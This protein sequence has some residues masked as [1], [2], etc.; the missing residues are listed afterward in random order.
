MKVRDRKY[1][2]LQLRHQN[3]TIK[4]LVNLLHSQSMNSRYS[5][6]PNDEQVDALLDLGKSLIKHGTVPSPERVV[7]SP[8]PPPSR[9][10]IYRHSNLNLPLVA[11]ER[12]RHD[13]GVRWSPFSSTRSRRS[14]LIRLTKVHE[15]PPISVLIR[16]SFDMGHIVDGLV[17]KGVIE[18]F[19]SRDLVEKHGLLVCALGED[20]IDTWVEFNGRE[21]RC[22]GIVTINCYKRGDAGFEGEPYILRCLVCE[23]PFPDFVFGKS[24]LDEA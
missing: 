1:L 10:S 12:S 20:D 9:N 16:T 17:D 13:L 21:Q 3:D 19:V 18:S 22:V 4:K 14:K 2:N 7:R 24:F 6:P 15:N 5:Q 23:E 8:I 11:P